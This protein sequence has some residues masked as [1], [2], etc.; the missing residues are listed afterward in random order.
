MS[1]RRFSA[2]ALAFAFALPAC[3]LPSQGAPEIPDAAASPQ[4]SAE[5]APLAVTPTTTTSATP[6]LSPE[7]GPPPTPLRSDAPLPSDSLG[8]D[9]AGYTLSAIFRQSEVTGPPRT[10]EVNTAGIDAARKKTELRLAVDLGASRMRVALLGNGYVVPPETELRARADRYGHVVLW[11][12]GGSYRPIAPGGLRAVLGE[13][14]FDVAPVAH[15]VVSSTDETG[16]R[17]GVR[18]RMVDVTTRVAKARFEVGRLPDLGE[19]GTL[20]CRMLLDLM[21]A[22]PGAPVCGYDELPV[23]AELRWTSRG[24]LSFELTGVLKKADVS[25]ASLL[26]PPPS[27]TFTPGTL[28]VVIAMLP[29]AD[30][31]SFRVGPIEVPSSAI[32]EG[33]IV[34]NATDEMRILMLD[35]VPIVAVAP[36]AKESVRGLLRGKYVAQWRSFLGDVVDPS[37]TQVVPGLA[38][39][40]GTDAGVK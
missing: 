38:Q 37:T 16:K 14:R 18:T 27:A 22:P 20:L 24:S 26:V 11:P 39:L 4:A 30:L 25:A 34:A 23:R 13:R 6:V 35:G 8:R 36:G 2:V 9:V 40:G 19:S 33:L 17:I 15:A 32:G 3:K 21:N 5:P 31:P 7:G 29:P 10:G 1:S 28:P 12:G